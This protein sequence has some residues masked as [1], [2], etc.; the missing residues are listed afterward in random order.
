MAMDFLFW[1]SRNEMGPTLF[2]RRIDISTNVDKYRLLCVCRV[3]CISLEAIFTPIDELL[4]SGSVALHNV[5][6]PDTLSCPLH[7]IPS[8]RFRQIA[9]AHPVCATALVPSLTKP[10]VPHDLSILI[11]IW[12][13]LPSLSLSGSII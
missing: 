6:I 13:F 11:L 8:N 4:W 12:H 3:K 2:R 7:A 10:D 9:H 1:H 5:G